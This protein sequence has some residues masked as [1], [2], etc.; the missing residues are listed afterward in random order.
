MVFVLLPGCVGTGV[1]PDLSEMSL[2]EIFNVSSNQLCGHLPSSLGALLQLR[3]LDVSFN[4][5]MDGDLPSSMT[6]LT[7][8]LEL[9]LQMTG[10]GAEGGGDSQEGGGGSPA[11]QKKAILK[12]LPSLYRISM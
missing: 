10:V 5:L 3:R 9:N 6:R 12:K 7:N 4:T 11:G 2:L 1:V 8:L